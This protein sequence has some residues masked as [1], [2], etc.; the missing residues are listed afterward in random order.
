MMGGSG[1]FGEM[2]VLVGSMLD[3][4]CLLLEGWLIVSRS[5]VDII[6]RLDRLIKDIREKWYCLVM[7]GENVGEGKK[8]DVLIVVY[9]YIF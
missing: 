1:I 4:D 2:G 8:G 5:L 7:E 9:G 3:Y 6:V